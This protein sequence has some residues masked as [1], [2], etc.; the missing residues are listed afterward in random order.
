[1]AHKGVVALLDELATCCICALIYILHLKAAFL[2]VPPLETE[3][4]FVLI[5]AK[6]LVKIEVVVRTYKIKFLWNQRYATC[7]VATTAKN[8]AVLTLK[9]LSMYVERL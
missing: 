4:S 1:M 5:H 6:C 9:I 2:E 3:D 7:D 8:I